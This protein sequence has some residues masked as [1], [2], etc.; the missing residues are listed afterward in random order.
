MIFFIFKYFGA[1]CKYALQ[2]CQPTTIEILSSIV[3]LIFKRHKLHRRLFFT[4][5]EENRC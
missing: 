4:N 2:K 3:A 1:P 5:S